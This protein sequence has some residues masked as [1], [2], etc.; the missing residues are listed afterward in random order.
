MTAVYWEVLDEVVFDCLQELSAPFLGGG[1][2]WISLIGGR[3]NEDMKDVDE[4]GCLTDWLGPTSK[5][6]PNL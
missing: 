1:G 5:V 2:P 4:H 6:S 3:R